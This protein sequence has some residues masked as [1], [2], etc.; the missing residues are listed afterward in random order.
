MMSCQTDRDDA[1]QEVLLQIMKHYHKYDGTTLLSSWI[2]N[3][4]R[5]AILDYLSKAK[6]IAQLEGDASLC[7][8]KNHKV[9][10]LDLLEK[11]QDKEIKEMIRLRFWEGKTL[12]EIGETLGISIS[13]VDVRLKSWCRNQRKE[14]SNE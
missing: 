8:L 4:G 3:Y 9:E 7:E 6:P 10:V 13:S 14:F 12:K 2:T 5:Y 11:E 1:F